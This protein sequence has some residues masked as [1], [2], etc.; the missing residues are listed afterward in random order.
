MDKWISRAQW[1]LDVYLGMDGTGIS[2]D[3]HRTESEARAVC[4][5]LERDGFGGQ[6]KAFPIRTWVEDLS[7]R[8]EWFALRIGGQWTR[9][10]SVVRYTTY[11]IDREKLQFYHP[12][13]SQYPRKFMTFD[14]AER[15]ADTLNSR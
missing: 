11:P 2:D 15:F 13:G 12:P 1:P 8:F 4:A 9:E 10:V 3:T 5:G 7:P 6:R 14:A